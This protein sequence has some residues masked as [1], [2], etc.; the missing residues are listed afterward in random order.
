MSEVA[1]L[2]PFKANRGKNK[3]VRWS[4]RHASLSDY[5]QYRL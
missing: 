5:T 2:V 4:L 3:T 1:G